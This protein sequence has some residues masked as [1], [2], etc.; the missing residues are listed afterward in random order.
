M[1]QDGAEIE[2]IIVAAQPQ[3]RSSRLNVPM[4]FGDF[5]ASARTGNVNDLSATEQD[6]EEAP[7]DV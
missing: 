5:A 6:Y 3:R 2:A 1:E 4:I 7:G